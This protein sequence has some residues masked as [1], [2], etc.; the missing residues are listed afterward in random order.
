LANQLWNFKGQPARHGDGSKALKFKCQFS[1]SGRV[2][3]GFQ[4]EGLVSFVPELKLL[5]AW[6]GGV[7]SV[8]CEV[9]TG[10]SVGCKRG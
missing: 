4:N 2:A 5:E 9:F 1:G 10:G 6:V 8:V 3:S 7:D